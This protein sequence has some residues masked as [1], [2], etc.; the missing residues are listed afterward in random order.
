ML[1]ENP[2]LIYDRERFIF[3]EKGKQIDNKSFAT[4]HNYRRRQRLTRIYR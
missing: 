1:S 2:E 4:L 3:F